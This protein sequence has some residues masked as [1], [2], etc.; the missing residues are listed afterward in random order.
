MAK[1]RRFYLLPIIILLLNSLC[2]AQSNETLTVSTYYPAPYGVY[3]NLRLYPSDESTTGVS[4][5]VMYFDDS[6][7]VGVLRYYNGSG[8]WVN[9][10]PGTGLFVYQTYGTL[11]EYHD[12]C[13]DPTSVS[14]FKSCMAAC[15][16]RCSYGCLP[17]GWEISRCNSTTP[18]PGL[19]FSGGTAVEWNSTSILCKCFY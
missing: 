2:L 19:G 7:S 15:N 3:Q 13:H 4:P 17:A 1:T 12:G 16:R 18:Q 14:P 6:S 10:V 9:V 11:Y 8:N 5:G